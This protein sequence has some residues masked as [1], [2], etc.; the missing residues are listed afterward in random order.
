[1]KQS[2]KINIPLLLSGERIIL[3]RGIGI[4]HPT[5]KDISILGYERFGQL[6]SIWNLKRSDLLK[7]ETD[8][9]WNLEDWDVIKKF[10]FFDLSLQKI[11]SDSV[12]FFLH[13]KVEYL[14]MSNSIFIGEL[15]SGIELTEEL[16]SEIQNV[17]RQITLQKDE[18]Q[19][20]KNVQRSKRA[21]EI[22]DKIVEG[23]KKLDEFNKEKG[24]D[25]LSSQIVSLVA[26]GFSYNDVYNMT[27]FQF[28]ALLEKI[29]QIENYK[30]TTL[31]SPY[32]DKKNKGKNKHWLE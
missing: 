26:H 29:V 20:S 28:K 1:M 3:Q 30:I 25:E 6:C 21:Q 14:K 24:R 8:E 19:N 7:E 22:H 23:Q 11:F 2:L 4:F 17:I 32:I 31:L 13:K 16:F 27:L 15:E 18:E 12:L 9:T 10:L 5:I